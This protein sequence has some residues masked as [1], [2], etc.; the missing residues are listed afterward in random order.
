VSSYAG[1]RI[2]AIDAL[3]G[4][5]VALM[6]IHHFLY[7]LAAFLGAPWWIFTNPVLDILHYIFAGCFILLSGVSSRFSRSNPGRGGKLLA[8]ALALTLV[9]WLGDRIGE[10]LMGQ[11]PGVLILFGVLHML[12][13]CMLFYG[14]THKLWDRLP[15][16][17]MAAICVLGTALTARLADGAAVPETL[18]CREYLFPFGFITEHFYSADYFPLFPWLFVF[19][20]GT[21]LGGKIREGKLPE[22]FYTFSAPF[23]PALGR[24]ALLIYILH[25]PALLLLTLGIGAILG[26]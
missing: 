13:L 19:L 21:W 24:R 16:W 11:A 20:F 15:D 7:D 23:F 17:L 6:C 9:T 18:T 10:K 12:A 25:Q 1:G 4:L 5:C 2:Q 8:I 14:L 26:I 3:R 22:R